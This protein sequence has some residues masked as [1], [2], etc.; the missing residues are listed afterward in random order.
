MADAT[1]PQ[2]P[3]VQEFE[4][5]GKGKAAAENVPDDDTMGDDDEDSSSDEDEEVSTLSPGFNPKPI[6]TR[7]HS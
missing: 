4:D 2:D 7:T 5:K 1:A 6:H 3:T